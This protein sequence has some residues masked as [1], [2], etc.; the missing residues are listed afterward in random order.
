MTPPPSGEDIARHYSSGHA[1]LAELTSTL[2]DDQLATPVPSTPGWAVHDVLAHLAAL[3]SDALA[4]RLTGVPTD[5]ITAEQVAAR[6]DLTAKELIE[7]WTANV[8]QMLSGARAGVV[9]AALA[10]DVLTHE[11]DIRGALRL[12]PILTAEELRFATDR[13]AR[14]FGHGLKQSDV[15]PVVIAASDSDFK[16]IA[17]EGDPAAEVRAAEF[18]LFRALAGRRSRSQVL[19]FDWSGDSASY[20]DRFN[21]FGRPPQTDITD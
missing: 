7:E 3:P 4:G 15:A 18:E 12:E 6:R 13:F 19:A 8:P 16:V 1:R 17:G 2:T 11:Q 9:P 21:V 20:A 14:G 10:V 5:E